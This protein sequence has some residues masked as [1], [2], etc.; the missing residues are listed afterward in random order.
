MLCATM[1]IV[2]V[3]SRLWDSIPGWLKT[4]LQC[5]QVRFAAAGTPL[6]GLGLGIYYIEVS[7]LDANKFAV[8]PINWVALTGLGYLLNWLIWRERRSSK[9][10]SGL[11]FYLAALACSGCSFSLFTWLTLHVGLQYMLAQVITA[12]AIG[13]PHYVVTDRLVFTRPKTATA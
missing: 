12:V 5:R 7:H 9:G 3:R 4:V 13:L 11:K 1:T 2:A 6:T 10:A 8:R